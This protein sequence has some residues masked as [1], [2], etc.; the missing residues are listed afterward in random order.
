MFRAALKNGE[1][2]TGQLVRCGLSVSASERAE[3]LLHTSF[4]EEYIMGRHKKHERAK[5]LDRKRQRR[6]KAQK[7]AI[8]EAKAAK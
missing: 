3:D 8:K 6:K 4:K 5:E 1:K 7:A 2:G